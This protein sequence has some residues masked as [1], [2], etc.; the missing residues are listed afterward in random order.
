V[1][2]ASRAYILGVSPGSVWGRTPR[3]SIEAECAR[4][5][6]DGVV[7]GCVGLLAGRECDAALVTALGGP[8]AR[9][10]LDGGPGSVSWYWVR[11]WAARGLLWA[12]DDAALPAIV[13]ALADD[14][15][16][17]REMAAKVVARHL[18]GDALPAV[19]G[20]RDDPVARVRAAASRAV[21]TL[22]SAD[23]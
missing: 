4:R 1:A 15:W 21:I 17:V 20:L 14:A 3:Q 22:T 2:G 7:A 5:G 6:K 16:R 8:G 23:A 11:V 19:A 12:W 13:A 9:V 10:V 18:L